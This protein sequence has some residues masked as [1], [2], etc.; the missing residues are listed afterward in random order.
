[1]IVTS[2]VGSGNEIV[3]V[4]HAVARGSRPSGR[5]LLALGNLY[6]SIAASCVDGLLSKC[7]RRSHTAL[8]DQLDYKTDVAVSCP[9]NINFSQLFAHGSY[10]Y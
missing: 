10:R 3:V 8:Q 5:C 6:C 2:V 7:W 9:W 1:M 4:F